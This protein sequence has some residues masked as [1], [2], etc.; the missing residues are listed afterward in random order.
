MRKAWSIQIIVAVNSR[1][2]RKS[3]RRRGSIWAKGAKGAPWDQAFEAFALHGNLEETRPEESSIERVAADYALCQP[4]EEEQPLMLTAADF[5]PV[6]IEGGA[7]I[8]CDPYDPNYL[9]P[10]DL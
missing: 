5:D 9:D 3:S 10:Y 7:E 1:G 8:S 4:V 2:L 6:G